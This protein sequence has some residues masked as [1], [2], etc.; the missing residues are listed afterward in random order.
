MHDPL[1]CVMKVAVQ[2]KNDFRF[3]LE[4]PYDETC[5]KLLFFHSF[6][7]NIEDYHVAPL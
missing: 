7:Q 1:C 3:K 2:R 4:Q 5:S 6:T